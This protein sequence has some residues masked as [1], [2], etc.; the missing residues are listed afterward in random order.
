MKPG[1]YRKQFGI[2]NSQSL[3][4]KS[5]TEARRQSA[6]DRGLGDN[7][8]KARAVRAANIQAKKAPVPAVRVKPAVPAVK[9]KASVPANV[10]KVT[11]ANKVSKSKVSAKTTK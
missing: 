1:Q 9:A 7:L 11:T 10:Q 3:S 2:P 5:F 4:A 8:A 6:L